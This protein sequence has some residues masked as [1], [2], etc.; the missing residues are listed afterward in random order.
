ML[1]VRTAL[2]CQKAG[3][4]H[5][6]TDRWFEEWF[7]RSRGLRV[8]P[9]LARAVA[10]MG[11]SH[12]DLVFRQSR[13]AA[14]AGCLFLI[15]FG[16]ATPTSLNVSHWLQT[17]ILMGIGQLH[18]PPKGRSLPENTPFCQVYMGLYSF[19]CQATP[20]HSQLL[21]HALLYLKILFLT[22]YRWKIFMFC[23]K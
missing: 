17:G 15:P 18:Y 5:K 11:R 19:C 9:G 20:V 1:L 23:S 21:M 12:R 2:L 7:G 22:L 3:E 10:V 4:R 13:A 6:W 8:S 16:A 14:V